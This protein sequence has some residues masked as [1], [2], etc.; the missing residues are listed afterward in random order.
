[1]LAN[2]SPRKPNEPNCCNCSASESLLV[3]WRCTA[4]F[5]SDGSIPC[6]LS[7]TDINFVPPDSIRTS[8]AEAPASREFS[9]SSFT[10]DNG[11]SI[12]SP[13]AIW[14]ITWSDNGEILRC[15][16]TQESLSRID[17]QKHGKFAL[18]NYFCLNLSRSSKDLRRKWDAENFVEQSLM[19]MRSGDS[20]NFSCA[21]SVS[22]H[23]IRQLNALHADRI[24]LC[25]L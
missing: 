22:G 11:R 4:R 7:S 20:K 1:M 23:L 9:T 3:Q 2:A 17:L 10:I 14:L 13:A 19:F 15:V 24:L 21:N 16:V 12:T 8:I 18:H 5:K 25:N 6:P